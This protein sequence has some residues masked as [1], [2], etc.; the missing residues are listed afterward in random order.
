M[1]WPLAWRRR[2]SPTPA[3]ARPT[4]RFDGCTIL[5]SVLVAWGL[6]E[7]LGPSGP[8]LATWSLATLVLAVAGMVVQTLTGARE[9]KPAAAANPTDAT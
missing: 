7:V 3:W 9:A 6:S 4:A 1:R 2:S 8:R 5:G